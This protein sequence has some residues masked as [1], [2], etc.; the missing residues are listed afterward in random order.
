MI[1]VIKFFFVLFLLAYISGC[2]G[3]GKATQ[4]DGDVLYLDHFK[5]ECFG[6]ILSLCERSKSSPDDEWTLFYDNIESFEYEWGY[7]YKLAITTEEIE[8]PP[9]DASSTEYTLVNVLS[10]VREAETSVFDLS[11][12]RTS[13]ERLIEKVSD[14]LYEIYSDVRFSCVA[15]QCDTIDSLIE[16][17]FSVL[18]QFSHGSD[19]ESPLK[20]VQIKCSDTREYFSNSCL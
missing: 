14:G 6:I 7:S 10:K 20:L 5:T 1:S 11:V 18:F 3:D 8:N 16:Q 2:G 4:S 13:S 12:S 15:E 17:D 19:D 9:E